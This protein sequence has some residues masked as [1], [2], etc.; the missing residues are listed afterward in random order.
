MAETSHEADT[1]T[2]AALRMAA[3][4]LSEGGPSC[5]QAYAGVQ[6]ALERFQPVQLHV[7]LTSCDSDASD[8]DEGHGENDSDD[9]DYDTDRTITADDPQLGCDDVAV[10]G[11]EREQDEELAEANR[12]LQ[13]LVKQRHEAVLVARARAAKG[14]RA[15]DEDH[16]KSQDAQGDIELVEQLSEAQAEQ[17]FAARIEH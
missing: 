4:A 16:T 15:I 10:R 2:V 17:L 8:A 6:R 9:D 13:E 3:A 11:R 12:I 14:K 5:A 1:D 7:D